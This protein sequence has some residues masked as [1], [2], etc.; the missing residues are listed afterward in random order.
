MIP[1]LMFSLLMLIPLLIS[2][3]NQTAATNPPAPDDVNVIRVILDRLIVPELKKFG[4]R[5]PPPLLVVADQTL[6][7]DLTGKIPD[8]WQTVLKPDARGWPGLIADE[9]RRQRVIDSFESRNAR[10]H[11]LPA[12]DRFDLVIVENQ[13]LGE[14]R[15]QY[16]DRPIGIARFSLPGYSPDGYAMVLASY[17][18]GEVCGI[19][20]LVILNNDAGIWHI[21]KTHPLSV[22]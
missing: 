22:S 5:D 6:S 20:L 3:A 13:R 15:Q 7:L 4:V 16:S 18:C 12:L 8:R 2:P 14:V 17:G 21:A 1:Q 11:Q 10:P 19:S 9:L